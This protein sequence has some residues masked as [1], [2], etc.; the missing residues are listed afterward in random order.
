MITAELTGVLLLYSLR[1]S[2]QPSVRL[3]SPA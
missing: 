3:L 2:L 1:T